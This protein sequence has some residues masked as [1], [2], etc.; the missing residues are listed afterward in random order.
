VTNHRLMDA[1][2]RQQLRSAGWR[3]LC[4]TVNEPAD[5]ERLLAL[6]VDGLIT[7]TV[8]RFSPAA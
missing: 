3:A 2:L 5:A 6:G 7:D 8:D 1:V 4:Y